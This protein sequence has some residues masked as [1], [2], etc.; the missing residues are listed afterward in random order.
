[1]PTY[2]QVIRELQH[3]HDRASALKVVLRTNY[4]EAE[5]AEQAAEV[6]LTD[7]VARMV[8]DGKS[9]RDTFD[10]SIRKGVE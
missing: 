2:A 6:A 3:R 9:P 8:Y 10:M 1:M 5:R 7:A 4:I